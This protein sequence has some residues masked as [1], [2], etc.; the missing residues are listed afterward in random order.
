M[1]NLLPLLFIGFSSLVIA[2]EDMLPKGLTQSERELINSY[3]FQYNGPKQITTPPVGGEIR[4]PG[5]WEENQ[6]VCIT[7]TG[8]PSIH[9][10]LVAAI[11]QECEVWI[12]C[13]DSN[14]VK[15]NITSNGGSLVNTRYFQLP[16]NSIWMRDYGP[17][18]VYLN[19]VDDLVF[20]DWIYNRPRP[21]DDATPVGIG[22]NQN[23]PVYTMTVAPY[24]LVH[25]GG[26][27]M[28]D[29]FGRGF[30]SLL[31][32]EEN[33]PGSAFTISGHDGA[34]VSN[35]MDMYQG[36]D[37]YV[38]M[39]TLP[40]DDI[41]HIDM[42]M[43][44]MNEEVLLV[45][46]FPT[47]SSDGPQIELN[48]QYIQD[49]YT[50]AFGTPFKIVKVPMPPATNGAFAPN[51]SYRT[52]ANNVIVNKTVIVPTYREQYDTTA[53]RIIQEVM[54]GYN[55]VGIDVDNTGAN[56][57]GQGGAL[58]CIT[59]E[60]ATADP[61][62]ISHQNHPD[63][64]DQINSYVITAMIRH[65]SGI[66][67]ATLYY[68][69]DFSGAYTSVSMNFVSGN[70]WS[71]NI[72]AQAAGT[73]IWY[74]IHAEAVSGK[75]QVRPMTA[76][77][78]YFTFLVSGESNASIQELE[79]YISQAVFP[80]PTNGLTCI[81]VENKD[82]F[83]GSLILFDQVGKQIQI[84]H[85]GKFIPGPRKY[86]FDAAN[87]PAGMYQLVLTTPTGTITQKIGVAK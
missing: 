43:K 18:S 39:T 4:T 8:F 27:F 55:V 36:I 30:S 85:E 21:N 67:N 60:V 57:I 2:Q 87:L 81:P 52:Y 33:D 40:Y 42:H 3:K 50:S 53:L 69:T 44:L 32:D 14:A 6:A 86:F 12:V 31:V 71:A 82:A 47:G 66:E 20:V 74:Y 70:N 65:K 46:E 37:Q 48:L 19:G 7:W 22:A 80:N 63:T 72:P 49:N 79:S 11:Q 76:P 34:A 16:F 38:K 1:K 5:Q 62:W 15:T 24:D 64:E 78:G 51:A 83:E 58:H 35:L 9:R 84:I 23:I 73:R 13:S 10:Q 25:T 77:E 26:N 59:K 56:L 41:H 68:K 75:Q 17:N 61:L 45:G 29:G 28:A 54:P